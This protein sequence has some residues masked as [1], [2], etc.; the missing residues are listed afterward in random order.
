MTTIGPFWTPRSED[1]LRTAVAGNLLVEDHYRD[2]K[3]TVDPGRSANKK[4]ACDIAAF[5]LDG[6]TIIIGVD[7]GDLAKGTS[8]SLS[9]VEL[10]GLPERI[11]SIATTA[12]HEPVRI[13]TTVIVADGQPGHGYLLVHI[14]QSP[15]APHMVDGRYYGRGN[16]ENRVLPHEEV[17]RWHQLRLA[18]QKDVLAETR[19]ALEGLGP[20]KGRDS[21][22]VILAEPLGAPDDL[23]VPLIESNA[24]QR[25]VLDLMQAVARPE[26]RECSPNLVDAHGF[27]RRA[28]GVA[29]T[30]GMYNGRRWE[31]DGGAAEIA[32]HENGTLLLASERPVFT[33][34]FQNVNPRPPDTEVVFESL[35]I[36]HTDL[37]IR[38][39]AVVGQQY[40]FTG[41]W[42]FGLII[43]GLRGARSYT[44]SAH[45]HGPE[46]EPYTADNYERATGATLLDLTDR[47]R[48]VVK[49]LL[50]TLLRGLGAYREQEFTD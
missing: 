15:R 30:T 16:V 11:E 48:A 32:F 34:Q 46:G 13:A 49:S 39:A 25:P 23:L 1:E 14:P 5:A 47:P 41:T 35:I 37:L 7:E 4:I 33:A 20:R 40:G 22:V 50:A 3:R 12:V 31:G 44:R 19:S 27:G 18:G 21:I 43:T 2:L 17:L 9:P 8:P 36:N 42:R 29:I 38:L 28:N 10:K 45:R 6:G 26:H 24:W